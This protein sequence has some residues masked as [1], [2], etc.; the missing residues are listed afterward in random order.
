MRDEFL[1]FVQI[2]ILEKLNRFF[3]RKFA[4]FDDVQP[5]DFHRQNHRLQTLAGA[6]ITLSN[7]HKSLN[8]FAHKIAVGFFVATLQVRD[9]TFKNALIRATVV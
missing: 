8:I 9:Y 5:S 6:N 2:K 4:N 7:T 3:D 1:P